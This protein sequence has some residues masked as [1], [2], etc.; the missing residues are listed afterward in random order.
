M[1]TVEASVQEGIAGHLF[2]V[3]VRSQ[4]SMQQWVF[5]TKPQNDEQ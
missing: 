2:R 1:L 3:R 5:K 4:V